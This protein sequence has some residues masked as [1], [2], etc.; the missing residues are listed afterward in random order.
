MKPNLINLIKKHLIST[1][2]TKNPKKDI[3]PSQFGASKIQ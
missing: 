2:Q 3:F 1:P